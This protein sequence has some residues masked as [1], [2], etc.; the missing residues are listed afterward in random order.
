MD[1]K[2]FLACPTPPQSI[3]SG[4]S[5]PRA[6]WARVNSPATTSLRQRV[7][8]SKSLAQESFLERT[9]AARSG[10]LSRGMRTSGGGLS[11]EEDVE[12]V[13]EPGSATAPLGFDFDR[14]DS[15]RSGRSATSSLLRSKSM[16]AE[17][18]AAALASAPYGRPSEEAWEQF[19]PLNDESEALARSPQVICSSSRPYTPVPPG[20]L[21]PQPP[22]ALASSPGDS[23][24]RAR[25]RQARTAS[26]KE[27]PQP[28]GEGYVQG[29]DSPALDSPGLSAAG[30]QAYREQ[31]SKSASNLNL[32]AVGWDPEAHSDHEDEDK[33]E[34]PAPR[35]ANDD[36]SGYEGQ[37]QQP[38]QRSSAGSMR[39]SA[40]RLG[41]QGPRGSG[42]GGYGGYD[43]G[44][45]GYPGGDRSSCGDSR[46][47]SLDA[48][49]PMCAPPPFLPAKDLGPLRPV[50]SPRTSM[51]GGAPLPFGIP[52]RTSASGSNL[53]LGGRELRASLSGSG[54]LLGAAAGEG[55]SAYS[56]N[57]PLSGGHSQSRLSLMGQ[58][59]GGAAGPGGSG[60]VGGF[61]IKV[62]GAGGG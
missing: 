61:A 2:P 16:G 1:T 30:R 39:S 49:G 57:G 52:H 20:G 17:A 35:W 23:A 19:Q 24:P 40:S 38:Y 44:Q 12:E 33:D 34:G 41:P 37:G 10:G 18:V 43:D 4:A 56:G 54:F 5:T 13:A 60:Y 59:S 53:G 45:E 55:P 50:N 51:T 28:L 62:R 3:P 21:S 58:G 48:G 36:A 47:G 26:F 32:S 11:D 8:R 15:S 6:S 25:L 22:S 29:M 14:P 27:G 7:L 42:N 31:R 9:G 46:R